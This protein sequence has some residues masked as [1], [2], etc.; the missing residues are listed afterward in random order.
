M[1]KI[2]QAM[3]TAVADKRPWSEG[4]TAVVRSGQPPRVSVAVMLHGN[5]IATVYETGATVVDYP[6]L[7]MYP[8][9]T[10]YSRL[11]ALGVDVNQLRKELRTDHVVY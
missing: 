7:R 4:N 8:T 10:T 2:E 5:R 6:M 11:R 1:R 3:V 9:Q